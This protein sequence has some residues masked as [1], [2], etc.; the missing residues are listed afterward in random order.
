M[1]TPTGKTVITLDVAP[2][3]TVMDFKRKIMDELVI[4]V[5]QQ[6][7][8]FDDK[9]LED[10]R[11]IDYYRIQ[12][13][14]TLQLNLTRRG[15][16][17]QLFVTP[18]RRT[19]MTLDVV[20]ED[21]IQTVKRKIMEEVGI[22]VDQYE[23]TVNE[24]K[25]EDGRT[26]SYYNIQSN[27][28]VHLA[29]RQRDDHRMR[30]FVKTQTGKTAIRLDV[31]LEDTIQTVKSKI[32]DE[33]GIPVDHHELTLDGKKLEDDHTLND[34]N[35]RSNTTLHLALTQRDDHMQLF[36]KTQTAKTEITLDV[37]SE[38]TLKTVKRKIMDEV[39]IPINKQQ[40][41]FA[42]K[43]LEDGYTLKDYNIGS[44][45]TLHLSLEFS[46]ESVV[47]GIQVSG[48]GPLGRRLFQGPH[49]GRAK[50]VLVDPT[51]DPSSYSPPTY[52]S[53]IPHPRPTSSRFH[54]KKKRTK[55]FKKK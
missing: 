2:N 25:L 10:D 12:K 8:I 27:S 5:H 42:E 24:K 21:T 20:P 28:T 49:R 44:G 6:E 26:L 51:S 40:F 53:S 1:K 41:T 15:D 31:V 19:V 55:I 33:V 34:Y 9:K 17:M 35:I 45:S 48:T 50:G 7:L 39:G 37:L 4:P 47:E 29:L 52:Y 30:L 16:N 36:V 18:I 43:T 14:S 11:T 23:L 46:L 54:S 32:T 3:D 22:A 13:E 38:D